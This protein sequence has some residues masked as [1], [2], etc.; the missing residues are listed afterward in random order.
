[1]EV[2]C[3]PSNLAIYYARLL[4]F[5]VRKGSGSD[6][7]PGTQ[8]AISASDGSFLLWDSHLCLPSW[9]E[10]LSFLPLFFLD[11]LVVFSAPLQAASIL[12]VPGQR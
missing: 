8:E 1:M 12:A 11:R 4:T 10:N 7:A 2:I 9:D 6:F 5:V 3:F